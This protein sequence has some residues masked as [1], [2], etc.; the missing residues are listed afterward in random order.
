MTSFPFSIKC[1]FI[2][3]HKNQ[4]SLGLDFEDILAKIKSGVM[5]IIRP[6]G[7]QKKSMVRQ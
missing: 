2:K 6:K 1:F 4:Q 7:Q 5:R 3:F